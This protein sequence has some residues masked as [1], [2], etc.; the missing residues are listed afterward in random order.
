MEPDLEKIIT[1]WNGG[2]KFTGKFLII[3]EDLEKLFTATQ[4]MDISNRLIALTNYFLGIKGLDERQ[5]G[6]NCFYDAGMNIA[7]LLNKNF[8]NDKYLKV[9]EE[10]EGKLNEVVTSLIAYLTFFRDLG[11]NSSYNG[12]AED[13]KNLY[14]CNMGVINGLLT[15]GKPEG[16]AKKNERDNFNS[17]TS[18]SDLIE[19]AFFNLFHEKP[20]SKRYHTQLSF[21]RVYSHITQGNDESYIMCM[22]PA[23]KFIHDLGPDNPDKFDRLKDTFISI[24]N[25]LNPSQKPTH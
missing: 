25:A 17:L 4:D 24:Y 22:I 15:N 12:I 11:D 9:K 19:L 7:I 16:L 6:S 5:R 3:G 8:S 1:K 2:K 13:L 10:L 23:V 20:K 18:Y 14:L 21:A